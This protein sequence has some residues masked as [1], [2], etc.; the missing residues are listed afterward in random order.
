M[1]SDLQAVVDELARR[2]DSPTTLEDRQQRVVVYSSHSGA[3]DEVRRDSILRRTTPPA[4]IAWFR[5]FGIT[6]ARGPLRIPPDT[7][8]GI[9]ARLCVPVRYQAQLMGYLWLID[10]DERLGE[11]EIALAER[12]AELAG[13]L[14]YQDWLSQGFASDVLR[15]LLSP[16]EELREASARDILESGMFPANRSCVAVVVQPVPDGTAAD[17]LATAINQGLWAAGRELAGS[18]TLRLARPDHG[19]LLLPTSEGDGAD[20][21]DGVRDTARKARDEVARF[22]AEHGCSRTIAA[23]GDAQPRLTL[24]AQSCRHARLAARVAAA[25]P[26]VGDLAE[27]RHLGVFR[28]LALLPPDEIVESIMDPRLRVLLEGGDTETIETIETYL[29]LG[30]DAKGT[31]ERLHLHRATVYYRLRKIEEATGIGLRDGSERLTVHLGLKLAR[32][33][34]VHPLATRAAPL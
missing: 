27:W 28:A 24:A 17:T 33:A 5:S 11:Q 14:M 2:V 1:T 30:C 3:I 18:V 8:Q 12:N 26:S 4:V 32:L 9:L 23:I 25:V 22:A 15:N 10:N 19:V 6:E 21:W 29:D 34:G 31:A 7:E 16:S 13:L 20:G